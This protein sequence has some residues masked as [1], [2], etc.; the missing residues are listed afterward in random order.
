MK[1]RE[2]LRKGIQ[3]GL[4]A[5]ALPAL[6]GSMPRQ[7]LGKGAI[8]KTPQSNNNHVLVMV[9]LSGGNDGLNCL[10]PITDPMYPKLRPHLGI[11]TPDFRNNILPDHPTLAMHERLPKTFQLYKSRRMT[12]LQNVG[13]PNPDFSHF[14]ATDIV[15]TCTDTNI[16][17]ESGWVGRLLRE[18]HPTFSM[19]QVAAGSDP[20]TIHFGATYSK[21]FK[22][23]PLTSIPG[24][25]GE[26]GIPVY[27]LPDP[28]TQSTHTYD[29]IPSNPDT[30]YQA[31]DYI[32]NVE[33]ET[34]VYNAVLASR[35]VKANK[36]TYPDTQLGQQLSSTAQ[37]IASGLGTKIYVVTQGGYDFHSELLSGQA[38]R[39]V[40]LDAALWAF[41]NDLEALGIADNVITMTYSEFG[42]RPSENGSGTDHGA[43]YPLF[44]IGTRVKGGT[45]GNDPDL[46][47]LINDNLN[48]DQMHDFRNVYATM[49]SEWLGVDDTTINNVLTASHGEVYS[50][51]STWQKLNLFIPQGVAPTV[52]NSK[53]GLMMV[54][55]HP[56]PFTAST[57]IEFALPKQMQVQLSIWNMAGQE[58]AR[59]VDRT[60][61]EGNHRV[62]FRPSG[63]PTGRYLYRLQ[64]PETQLAREMM[65]LK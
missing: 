58:V 19:T 59:L 44:V 2:F 64:T 24:D 4:A 63:L 3:I 30:A 14:R 6:I 20:L 65:L 33:R 34:E 7:I 8:S 25:S 16:T 23:K 11:N 62:E 43:S 46:V 52:E 39:H 18:Q 22:T 51:I 60:M 28:V 37:L 41:Q 50:T 61:S 9:Q 13:Y 10:V 42:R 40:D 45:L 5:P 29:P 32:R 49:M 35:S 15:E 26:M 55:N 54:Q 53:F 21:L 48:Y 17:K 56:N 38:A 47:N 57:T 31:L 12:I 36:V 27:Q 1:R